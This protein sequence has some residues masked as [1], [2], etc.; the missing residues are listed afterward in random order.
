[1]QHFL[2]AVHQYGLPSCVRSDQGRENQLVTQHMLECRGSECRSM[3]TGSSVHNQ[4]IERLWGDMYRCVVFYQLFYF[5]EEQGLMD[6][7]NDIHIFALHFVYIPQ[8]NKSLTAFRE[9]WNNH[10]VR[11]EHGQSPY[12][13]FVAGALQM[14]HSGQI[15]LDFFDTVDDG[16]SIDEEN[17]TLEDAETTGVTV[18]RGNF[19]LTEEHLE[20]L[21]TQVTVPRG[22]FALT[23]EHL[24]ELQTQVNPIQES[25]NHGIDATTW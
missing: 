19:A 24:E 4:R 6:P 10:G 20:E 21:Q 16:Y 25:D 17:V 1:M 5:L 12:Q 13:L 14:Q 7:N 15:A 23:E 9:G 8:V 18:P 2:K 11:T 22:D 3:I